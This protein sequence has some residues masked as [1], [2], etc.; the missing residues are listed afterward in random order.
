MATLDMHEQEQVDALKDW[1]KDNG[2][3]LL[4]ALVLAAVAFS[5]VSGWKY[6]RA[7]RNSNAAAMYVEVV[8]QVNSKDPKRI[9]DAV[10]AIADKYGSTAYAPRAELMAAQANIDAGDGATA[11]KQLNWVIDHASED[12]LQ[13]VARLKLASLFL[14]EKKYDDALKLLEEKHP[15]AYAG[16][17][18]DLKGDVLN[19]QGKAGEARAAYKQ[20]L[21]KIDSKSMFRSLV[22]MKLDGLGG[23]K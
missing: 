4:L 18:L 14:D 2:G 20:A 9:N 1:W 17:Y 13:N 19:A 12:G 6:W 21:D 15:D 7:T 16:L 3:G 23:A 5:A 10:A 8:K 11:A 22:Q